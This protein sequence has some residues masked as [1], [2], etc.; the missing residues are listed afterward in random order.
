MNKII[1]VSRK[2]TFAK[3][4]NVQLNEAIKFTKAGG[5]V[6]MSKCSLQLN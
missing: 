1:T 5:S 2:E 6:G 4:L 3:Q